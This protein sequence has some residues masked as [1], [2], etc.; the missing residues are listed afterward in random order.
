MLRETAIAM[1]VSGSSSASATFWNHG[2]VVRLACSWTIVGIRLM[3]PAIRPNVV[4]P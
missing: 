1:S 4:A 2:V 3:P